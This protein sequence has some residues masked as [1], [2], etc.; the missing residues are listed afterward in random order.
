VI[1]G[2]VLQRSATN[3]EIARANLLKAQEIVPGSRPMTA[4]ASM[5]PGLLALQ[6]PLAVTLDVQNL[7]GQRI[8]ESNAARMRLLER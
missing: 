2:Q 3:P 7:I 5:D 8:S 6:N 1:A 4:E